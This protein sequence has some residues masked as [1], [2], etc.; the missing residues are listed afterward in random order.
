MKKLTRKILL[1]IAAASVLYMLITLKPAVF[2][3]NQNADPWITV[4]SELQ[5]IS[6]ADI[7]NVKREV[8]VALGAIPQILGVSSYKTTNIQIVESGIC[9]ATDGTVSLSV[10]HI[11]DSSAPII[12]EVTHILANHGQNS[13]F[14]E[15]LAVYF[16]ERF[17]RT[18]GFPNFS[19]PLDELVR[20]HQGQL[21]GLQQLFK[22]NE[23]FEQ[24][25]TE[26]RRLAYIEA[27]SFINFL[28]EKYGE[29]KL[30][31]LH[32]SRTL[33]YN[34]VYGKKLEKLEEEWRNFVLIGHLIKA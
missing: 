2:D 31:D 32:N 18:S 28:V 11:R 17:G 19:V 12:H 24:V 13:F 15:G 25:G 21:L 4:S 6:T 8:R 7:E 16:Q 22:D 20:Y 1:L 34:K 29:Q 30:A 3:N 33:N 23:I 10:D 27:G 5:D 9:Y 14:S 26:Q